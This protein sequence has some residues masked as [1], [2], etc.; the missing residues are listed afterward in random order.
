MKKVISFIILIALCTA[1]SAELQLV[2]QDGGITGN[3]ISENKTEKE[4]S[5]IPWLLGLAVL[6]ALVIFYLLQPIS[7]S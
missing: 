4:G 2:Y 7:P 3:S 6:L 1:V 5:M